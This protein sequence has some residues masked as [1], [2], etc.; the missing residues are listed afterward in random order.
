DQL[1][2]MIRRAIEKQQAEEEKRQL[3]EQLA[4]AQKME[5]LGTLAAGIAHEYNNI[6]AAIIGY[7]DLTLQ[8]EQ[9]S[10]VA[11]RNLEVVRASGARAAHLTKS[12]LAF[13][14]KDVGEKRLVNLRDVA[15]KVLEV[16]AKEFSTE[17]IDVT[18]K[19][20]TRLPQVMAN[21][22]MLESVLMNL[23][24]NARHAMLKSKVK[25]LTIQTGFEKGKAFIRVA[26][27]GSGI[28]EKDI[29][30][31]FDPFFTTKGAIVSGEAHDGKVHGTGLG[32]S[33]SHS[34]VQGHG[35]EI[36]VKSQTG[37]GATFT[38]Y[39]PPA[40]RRT[41]TRP[42]LAKAG[43]EHVSPIMVVDDEQA[44][45]ELLVDI[46]DAAGHAAHGFTDPGQALNALRHAQYSLAFI[47]IQMPEMTGQ[48]L[49]EKINRLPP[50]RRP[51]KVILTGRLDVSQEDYDHLD[52][53]AT[54]PKPFTTQLVLDLV[55]EGLAAR[56]RPPR[57]KMDSAKSDPG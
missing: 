23:V 20:S 49:L 33:V 30:R 19:H 5:A 47:D 37:R 43:R 6:V 14:R 31:I 52:V 54:L 46:L 16:T 24:V 15:D 40:S 27:T 22:P 25:K 8:A 36:K 44:I 28:P 41:M 3:Q 9:L 1:L 21:A 26:D 11:R 12:L 48:E 4:L 18:A 55:E 42:Q 10:D 39:L 56:T 34:I 7:T 17:G 51:L 57:A 2:V 45:T 38:V 29:P 53:F 35:G 13:S 50:H 32:L